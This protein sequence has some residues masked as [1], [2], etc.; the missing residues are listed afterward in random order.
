MDLLNS[1]LP[2]NIMKTASWDAFNQIAARVS[3]SIWAAF[4]MLVERVNRTH[5]GPRFG[6][7]TRFG[8]HFYTV[9]TRSKWGWTELRIF[10]PFQEIGTKVYD[11]NDRWRHL[12]QKLMLPTLDGATCNKTL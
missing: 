12:Q 7:V 4:C 3:V 8:P 10:R 1:Q 11:F 6:L 2:P 5:F 9:K